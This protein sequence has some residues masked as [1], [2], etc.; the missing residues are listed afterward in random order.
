MEEPAQER[1]LNRALLVPGTEEKA[2]VPGTA[3]PRR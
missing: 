2:Y 1:T 3:D